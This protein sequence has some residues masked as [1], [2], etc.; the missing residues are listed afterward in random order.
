MPSIISRFYLPRT[1]SWDW[2][3]KDMQRAEQK[4]TCPPL[5]QEP[6]PYGH[7][8]EC[9]DCFG[10]KWATS[11]AVFRQSAPST[12]ELDGMGAVV[13]WAGSM[14]AADGAVDENCRRTRSHLP[15]A[16]TRQQQGNTLASKKAALRS[17]SLRMAQ[18]DPRRRE[19]T[20]W[21]AIIS[22][23]SLATSQKIVNLVTM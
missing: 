12:T 3:T 11:C 14:P 23:L 10:I 16:L 13:P 18:E 9:R 5:T 8:L 2:R 19:F 7:R 17:V 20:S 22:L 21:L 6:S 15:R 4:K 1:I